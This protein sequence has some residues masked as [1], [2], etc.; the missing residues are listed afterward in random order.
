MA[1]ILIRDIAFLVQ[2][3]QETPAICKGKAMN[4]LQ[5]MEN[6]WLLIDNGIVVDF[7]E[8]SSCP[9]SADEIIIAKEKAVFPTW[10]DPHTHI[11]FHG[12]REQEFVYKLQNMSYEEIAKN[13]GGIL[14]SAQ[15]LQ[16]AT[17]DE[18]YVAAKAR[19]LEMISFGT[20][21]IE[22]KSGYGLTFEDEMKMLRVIKRLKETMPV[23]IKATLL[24]AHALPIEFRNNRE[25]FIKI[26]TDEMIPYAANEGLADY[27]DVFCDKG[28][29]TPEETNTMLKAALKYGISSKIHAN[30]LDYSGGIQIGVQNKA[31]SVDHLEFTGDDEINALLK[32][33]KKIVS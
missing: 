1:S 26:V 13:G 11:V 20:G 4:D 30:E 14:N 9:E 28:F 27:F 16:N 2:A 21:A 10:C 24:G 18:L 25:Q 29:F 8:M 31:I 12:S 6:A 17:E 33:K 15:K 7:G 23:A 19:V 22:I 3:H 32:T 5:V